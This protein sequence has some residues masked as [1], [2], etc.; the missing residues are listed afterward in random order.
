MAAPPLR[1]SSDAARYDHR[2]G[3]DDFSQPRALFNLCDDDQKKRLFSHLAAAMQG[4]PVEIVERQLK[5]F[6][7]VHPDYGAGF[8]GHWKSEVGRQA[9][10]REHRGVVCRAPHTTR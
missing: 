8:A 2:Q 1:I 4:V 6:D 5:L 10:R 7:E 3:N 9:M